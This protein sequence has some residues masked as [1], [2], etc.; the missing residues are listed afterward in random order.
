MWAGRRRCWTSGV[1]TDPSVGW[2]STATRMAGR[3]GRRPARAP[4]TGRRLRIR[5]GSCRSPTPPSTWS[6][7][8][9][10]LEHCEPEATV[11]SELA[12][13]LVPG[14]RL[15]VSVPA[16]QWAWS[17]FDVQNR[18]HRRYTQRRLVAVV[19]ERG[20]DVV[21]ATYLFAGTFPFFVADRLRSRVRDGGPRPGSADAPA[22][23]PGDGTAG[24]E[25]PHGRLRA[26]PLATPPLRPAV[27]LLGRGGCAEGGCLMTW[28][29]KHA[30]SIVVPVYRGAARSTPA[31]GAGA[32]HHLF[33]T[34]QGRAAGSPRSSSSTTAVPTTP[35]RLIRELAHSYPSCAR[36]G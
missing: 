3:A 29:R 14:G 26:R 35:G 10:S 1:P 22:P 32:L 21:R 6:L 27:R 18:H 19:K 28:S 16:Y 33:A 4:H 23:T 17:E 34:P 15:L 13:V 20:L 25:G 24:R 5:D 30:L 2:L 7:P 11:L 8:S 31:R 9:T 36:S 12:R